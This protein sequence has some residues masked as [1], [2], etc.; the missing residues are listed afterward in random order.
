MPLQPPTNTDGRVARRDRTRRAIVDAHM[1]LVEAGDLSPTGERIAERAGVSLRT[2]WLHFRD[3][4]TLFAAVADAVYLR[5]QRERQPVARTLPLPA[6]IDAYSLERARL[7]EI[8]APFARASAMRSGSSDVLRAF[9]RLHVRTFADE[10]EQLFGEDLPPP[11]SPLRLDALRALVVAT[12][13]GAWS[14]SRDLLALDVTEATA[15]LA[16]TFAD[17][18]TPRDGA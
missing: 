17:V 5:M 12:S 7:L 2:F 13:W 18:L 9:E 14:T 16:R 6:R 8:L 11:S 4:N 15:V 3:M 1:A 10:I